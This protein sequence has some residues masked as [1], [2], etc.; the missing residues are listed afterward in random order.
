MAIGYVF[1]KRKKT[2][3]PS[4]NKGRIRLHDEGG[5][6]SN[7]CD[8]SDMDTGLAQ[9]ATTLKDDP[10]T[11]AFV[12]ELFDSEYV[13]PGLSGSATDLP[14]VV[15]PNLAAASGGNPVA[16]VPADST[17]DSRDAATS[18]VVVSTAVVFVAGVIGDPMNH[19]FAE[20]DEWFDGHEDGVD[21]V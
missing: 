2:S 18:E 8:V 21:S 7:V 12:N 1:Q 10:V 16:A 4:L 19:V 6:S 3:V 13:D 9:G 11:N 5:S 17:F 14:T 20:L 15:P